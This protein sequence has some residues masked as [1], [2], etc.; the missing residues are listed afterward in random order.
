[1]SLLPPLRSI[2]KERNDS[3]NV[4]RCPI[5]HPCRAMEI[6]FQPQTYQPEA[7]YKVAIRSSAHLFDRRECL[8][9]TTL[10]LQLTLVHR[11]LQ[12]LV[13]NYQRQQFYRR[14]TSHPPIRQTLKPSTSHKSRPLS[15]LLTSQLFLNRKPSLSFRRN[16]PHQLS[17]DNRCHRIYRH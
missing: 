13:L 3:S 16:Q 12:G 1:M 9:P 4:R 14:R 2:G 6:S 17:P 5:S 15:H 11:L 10:S 8:S 7:A